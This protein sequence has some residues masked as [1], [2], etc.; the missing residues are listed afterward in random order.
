M[1]TP[2]PDELESLWER[3]RTE[4][5][6]EVS[7]VTFHAW[8]APLEVAGAEEGRIYLRAPGHLRGWVDEH[9]GATLRTAAGRATGR[10]TDVEVVDS[11]W[12][13]PEDC[14]HAIAESGPEPLNPKYT[15]G[16]F[17][18]GTGSHMAHAAAL[19]VAE[20][21]SQA[22]NPLFIH[23]RPGVG[24]TH[25]LQAIGNYVQLHGLGL[26]VRYATVEA[27][28]SGFLRAIRDRSTAGFKDSFRTIDVL[29]VDDAQFLAGKERTMEEFFHTFDALYESGKQLVISS[30]RPPWELPDV[31]AR[32]R[33]RFQAGL[34]AELE[35]PDL[36]V[37]MVILR[38][39]ARHDAI[40]R[41]DDA[42]LDTIARRVTSSVRALEG[43]LIRVVAYAS[44]RGAAPTPELAR[45]V[46]ER[47]Y[48]EPESARPTVDEVVSEV[49]REFG[50]EP[51]VVVAH[52]RRR[53]HV[54]ARQV[55]MYL[56]RELTGESLPTIGERIGGRRHST[57]LTAHRRVE[58]VLEGRG[59][60]AH[61]V[62]SL[63]ER[64]GRPS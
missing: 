14:G 17:V 37:R 13:R 6:D 19:K 45:H 52:D 12:R 56:A 23:G 25:L 48:P 58:G 38:A 36:P 28:T 9:L 24:K 2:V 10:P 39:R 53:P 3:L 32:L 31:E 44:L 7:E 16:Q 18:I 33:E 50:L 30:D 11:S 8:L 27:F 42:T 35:A 1:P 21:P 59:D 63:R 5:R 34:V 46:L 26:A 20:M 4:L 54:W 62:L 22:Y 29:L 60:G 64:L 40:T 47:L 41:V 49:G 15:F 51:S 55:A 57:L 61:V 43:A